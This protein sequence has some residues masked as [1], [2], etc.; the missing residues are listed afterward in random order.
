MGV[1]EKSREETVQM[2]WVKV[3]VVLVLGFALFGKFD[4][5]KSY[6]GFKEHVVDDHFVGAF[7][8][9]VVDLD[10]DGDPD[11]LVAGQDNKQVAWYENNGSGSFSKHT[12]SDQFPAA[13]CVWGED[14]NQDGQM[15]VLAASG[16]L[17]EI[18]WWQNR[19][20]SFSEHVVDNNLISAESVCAADFTNDGYVDIAA[21]GTYDSTNAVAWYENRGDNTFRK[22]SIDPSLSWAHDIFPVDIDQDGRMDVVVAAANEESFIWYRN[23]GDGSF[24]K[25]VFGRNLYGAYSIYGADINGDGYPDVEGAAHSVNEVIWWEN[26]G[27]SHLIIHVIDSNLEDAISVS[28]GDAN[29]DGNVDILATGKSSNTVALY[30]NDGSEHFTKEIVSNTFGGARSPVLGDFNGDGK[31]DIAAAALYDDKI[32]WW[33]NTSA[34]APPTI[35]VDSPNGGEN[36]LWGTTH[37]IEWHSTGNISSVN[38]EYSTDGG[39]SWKSVANGI[40]NSGSYSWAIP[41]DLSDSC[42]VRVVSATNSS[43]YDHSDNSFSISALKIS[44]CVFYDYSDNVIPN[45]TLTM[46][47]PLE[48][49]SKSDLD[50]Y[51][52]FEPLLPNDNY[53][54]SAQKNSKEDV[55][56]AT[57]EAYDAALAARYSVGLG[58]L[59]SLARLAADV[60]NDGHV[61][62]Y[63]AANIARYSVGLSVPSGILVGNWVFIPP[64]AEVSMGT[65]NIPNLCFRGIIKG[66]VN[67]NWVYPGSSF[68]KN[69]TIP[70][71]SFVDSYVTGDTV[72]VTIHFPGF[73]VLSIDIDLAFDSNAYN[74]LKITNEQKSNSFRIFTNVSA[75]TIRLAGFSTEY[76]Q[77]DSD[78]L[79]FQFKKRGSASESAISISKLLLNGQS[80]GAVTLVSEKST[81]SPNEFKL[82]RNY[83]NPFNGMTRCMV[84]LPQNGQLQVSVYNLLGAKILDLINRSYH[85]GKYSFSWNGQNSHGQIV[86]SGVYIIVAKYENHIQKNKVLFVK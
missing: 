86:P 76:I 20:G 40:S 60:D 44:G 18:V 75:N 32:S 69:A 79:E 52:S 30:V 65:S 45:V 74:L 48:K 35:T 71:N 46:T 15:D 84:N 5:C 67:G 19:S 25:N 81:Y 2:K 7:D 50:G 39:S 6:A 62:M 1:I 42:R 66:D 51:F 31:T 82:S 4:I 72:T 77:T 34:T 16:A 38:I 36:W 33:E 12:I 29:N 80:L 26:D 9:F 85:S 68:E 11:L 43:V 59:D 28:A 41:N 47:G 22:K 49:V 56:G 63:D 83:P 24:D 64:D 70:V 55:S 13:W 54:I 17:N 3:T 58:N 57:I 53:V 61:L 37:S 10:G 23:R 73:Q 27:G 8:L 78:F 21:V 14:I